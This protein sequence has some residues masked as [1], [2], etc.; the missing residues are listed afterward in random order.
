MSVRDTN[1]KRVNVNREVR[2]PL[3]TGAIPST[4]SAST[5]K[6]PMNISDVIINNPNDYLGATAYPFYPLLSISQ[7][8]K[9]EIT[10]DWNYKIKTGDPIE[11]KR[12]N[13]RNFYTAQ[14]II[15]DSI[16]NSTLVT[17]FSAREI[18]SPL[19]SFIGAS[20]YPQP[21]ADTL[22]LLNKRIENPNTREDLIKRFDYR[23]NPTTEEFFSLNVLWEIDPKVKVTK[24]RWRSI[25]RNE[26]VSNVSYTVTTQG[27]YSQIPGA[28]VNS[29]TGRSAEIQLTGVTAGLNVLVTGV[30]IVQQGGNYLTPPDVVIDNTYQVGLTAASVTSSL[31]LS[32]KGRID[33]IRV[34]DGGLGYTGASVSISGSVLSDNAK[35]TA[36]ITN[37][38]IQ[39]IIVT[40]PGH[41]YVGATVSII[42]TG[43]GGTGAYA[44]ANVDLYSDWVYEENMFAEKKKTINGFK[45]NVPYEIQ[46]LVSTDEYFRGLLHYSDSYN[47]QYVKK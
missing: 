2:V 3:Q 45:A 21:S 18:A 4:A 1:T 43:T 44:K 14:N 23:M 35:A 10:G 36:I 17:L 7:D 37:G 38:S 8:Y 31:N 32:N 41:G 20:G 16:S 12:G 27:L 29:T 13:I 5:S 33:Y 42:P 46:L 11:I 47:F 6:Y 28:V 22:L 9:L 30:T 19:D 40:Y 39:N 26:N 25:P 34:L 15:F 24:L